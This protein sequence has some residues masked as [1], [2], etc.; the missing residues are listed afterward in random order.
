MRTAVDQ[1]T[2]SCMNQ[3]LVL[4]LIKKKKRITRAGI[5][6]TLKLSPPSVSANIEKLLKKG[7]ILEYE[8]DSA[9]SGP[10]RKGTL[11][12]MNPFFSYTIAT[13]SYTHLKRSEPLINLSSP[14]SEV[15]ARIASQ[16]GLLLILSPRRT[17]PSVNSNAVEIPASS[18][19]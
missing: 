1:Q 3:S 19:E 16:L 6:Q 9:S 7:L 5:S 15:Q 12:G 14:A 2:I 13:V 4:N 11:I 10:G 8:E 18:K 17:F